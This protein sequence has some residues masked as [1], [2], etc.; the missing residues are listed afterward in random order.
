MARNAAKRPQAA[1]ERGRPLQA[2]EL[3]SAVGLW[4]RLAQQKDLRLFN[5]A[6][7]EDG[8]S[9]LLYAILLVVEAN[10][11]CRQADLGALLRIRQPN[12]VEPIDSLISRGLVAR[13]PDPR[14]RRA[15]T[16]SLTAEGEVL[17]ARL[18]TRHDALI[19]GYRARLGPENYARLVEL[20]RLFTTR[21]AAS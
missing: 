16:L 21:D 13:A 11:G 7:A 12:L 14:D 3:E 8:I 6:F 5:Q 2:A 15:Q 4:L 1:A 10:P 19:D 20:L 17:L 18:R 9:Q